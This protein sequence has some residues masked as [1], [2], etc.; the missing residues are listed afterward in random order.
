[1]TQDHRI[2]RALRRDL[3]L[4]VLLT[5]VVTLPGMFTR[6]LWMPDESRY[7][8]VAREMVVLP[9]YVIPKLN[10]APYT[11]KPPVFFWLAGAIYLAGFGV[12]SARVLAALASLGTLLLTYFFT[13]RFLKGDGPL[14]SA[15]ATLGLVLFAGH[16]QI[17]VIDPFHTLLV[18][19]ATMSGYMA[20][21]RAGKRPALWWLAAYGLAA[22]DVLT[23]GP[24]GIALPGIVLAAY[25]LLHRRAVRAGGWAH[26]AGTA[27]LLL[28]VLA[29]LVPAMLVGGPAYARELLGRKT[30]GYV[31]DSWNH[32]QPI[33]YFVVL[34]PV[35]LLPWTLLLVPAVRLATQHRR[36][37]EARPAFFALVWLALTYAFFS[38]ISAKRFAYVLPAA[39]AVGL[40]VGWLLGGGVLEL[41]AGWQRAAVYLSRATAGAFGVAFLGGMGATLF[42]TGRLAMVTRAAAGE[43]DLRWRALALLLLALPLCCCVAAWF[44]AGRNL[45]RAAAALAVT[46]VLGSVWFDASLA[47]LMNSGQS[48][49]PFCRA[50][51]PH[52]SSSSTLYL[53]NV[54]FS[55]AVNLYTGRAA[56]PTLEGAPALRAALRDPNALVLSDLK[57][58]DNVLSPE[59]I[60]RYGVLRGEIDDRDVILLK[61]QAAPAPGG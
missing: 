16:A 24:V 2:P 14:L 56:I 18:T 55:G 22:L 25:A 43:F 57:R 19:G 21:H 59:E 41:H 15:L 29:W 23:K 5:A 8:E 54:D 38:C 39:P 11:D 46:V 20:L 12:M 1:M 36:E 52:L 47:P 32:A 40:L 31:A 26:L 42:L 44:W 17:G 27:L 7:M 9:S 51:A 37:A 34:A 10:A 3:A 35:L 49:G 6:D 30:I 58:F 13:R 28:I 61:G 60:R 48:A 45:A 4:I 33:Y 53:Y 50:L